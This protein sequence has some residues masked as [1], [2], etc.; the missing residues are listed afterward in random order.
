[1][2]PKGLEVVGRHTRVTVGIVIRVHGREQLVG[3]HHRLLHIS[4]ADAVLVFDR[5]PE[6]V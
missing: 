3:Q 5:D 6:F 4:G 1:M 2:V